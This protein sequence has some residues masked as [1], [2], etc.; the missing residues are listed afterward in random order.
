MY[1]CIDRQTKNQGLETIEG[2]DNCTPNEVNA[3][4]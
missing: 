3:E 1:K 2:L 4:H